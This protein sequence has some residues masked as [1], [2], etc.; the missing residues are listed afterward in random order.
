MY[1][2]IVTV[3]TNCIKAATSAYIIQHAVNE[4]FKL[5]DESELI[6]RITKNCSNSMIIFDENGE[7]LFSTEKALKMLSTK[8]LAEVTLKRGA[9]L[10]TLEQVLG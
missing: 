7:P 3:T 10:K 2:M 1:E 6:V 5:K 4:S 9:A 8:D